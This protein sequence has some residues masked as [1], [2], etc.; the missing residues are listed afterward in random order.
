MSVLNIY[1]SVQCLDKCFCHFFLCEISVK[2]TD[3]SEIHLNMISA[4]IVA[5]GEPTR[6]Q[7]FTQQKKNEI[8]KKI[9]F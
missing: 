7:F 8:Q 3:K 6:C 4:V 5:K 9:L 1:A 2:P